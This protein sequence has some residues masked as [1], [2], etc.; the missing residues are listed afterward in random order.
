MS[1]TQKHG[2]TKLFYT[3]KYRLRRILRNRFYSAFKNSRDG[4][5]R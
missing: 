2:R 5:I 1:L 3:W 4:S